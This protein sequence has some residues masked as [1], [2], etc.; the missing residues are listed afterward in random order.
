MDSSRVIAASEL[1]SMGRHFLGIAEPLA[2]RCP[3]YGETW[4][5]QIGTQASQHQPLVYALSQHLQA[6][7]H[8]PSRVESGAPSNADR[9]LRMGVVIFDQWR[10]GPA[11]G[12]HHHHHR[13]GGASET[14]R[15]Q[16]TVT[17]LYP[18]DGTHHA[19]PQA[20]VHV[21]TGSADGDESATVP[22]LPKR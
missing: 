21:R 11:H 17:E 3:C 2:A 20:E 13:E 9:D 15:G 8:P 18:L 22:P 6:T 5:N 10:Q 16:S 14:W 1:I 4:A 19:D 12:R 7:V